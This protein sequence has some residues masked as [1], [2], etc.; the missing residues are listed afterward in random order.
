MVYAGIRTVSLTG[1]MRYQISKY[2]YKRAGLSFLDY[3]QFSM[4]YFHKSLLIFTFLYNSTTRE[5]DGDREIC[6][7]LKCKML[8][9]YA[10][11][12]PLCVQWL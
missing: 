6:S 7:A 5:Y 10:V 9:N 4:R 2:S 12:V 11:I 1:K 8:G 3:N